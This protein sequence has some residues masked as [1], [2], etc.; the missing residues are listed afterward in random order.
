[1]RVNGRILRP[2]TLAE[3]RFLLTL[4]TSTI[5]VPRRHNPYVVAR[6]LSR[7]AHGGPERLGFRELVEHMRERTPP[8]PSPDVDT[9]DP[10]EPIGT[11]DGSAI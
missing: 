7:A 3:R 5:R 9:A 4:G 8:V 1:M 6:R 2:A 11:S 10:V